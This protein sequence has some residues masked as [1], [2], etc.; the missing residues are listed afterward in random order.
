L[1]KTPNSIAKENFFWE[2][3]WTCKISVQKI[4]LRWCFS[5]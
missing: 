4:A 2:K 1:A 5:F 3:S